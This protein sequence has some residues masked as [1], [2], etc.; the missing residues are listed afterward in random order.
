MIDSTYIKA[1]AAHEAAATTLA[2]QKGAEHSKLH[3]AV[4][5]YGIS[6][7]GTVTS[8]TVADYSQVPSL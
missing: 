6:A 2:A 3:L 4:D 8:G 7:S 1:H 5:E